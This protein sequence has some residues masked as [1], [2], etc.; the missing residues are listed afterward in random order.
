[1]RGA[2]LALPGLGDRRQRNCLAVDLER[3]GERE[4]EHPL[5][6]APLALHRSPARR[7]PDQRRA[8]V[9]Q[10]SQ[11][12]RRLGPGGLARVDAQTVRKIKNIGDGPCMYLVTGG[13]DGYVGRDG[14]L[15][16]GEASRVMPSG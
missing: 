4:L 1:M 15:P 12:R 8:P 6:G 14:R 3:P 9:A 13:K 10:R 2:R 11:R 5:V 7:E 16:E